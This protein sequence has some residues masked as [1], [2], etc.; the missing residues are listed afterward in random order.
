MF[1]TLFYL[2]KINKIQYRFR[3]KIVDDDVDWQ[4]MVKEEEAVEEEEEEDEAPVVSL[5]VNHL[6]CAH[7]DVSWLL[8]FLQLTF[9]HSLFCQCFTKRKQIWRF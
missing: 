1:S 6:L 4:Q 7:K 3:L 2:E 9:L 5:H 8:A